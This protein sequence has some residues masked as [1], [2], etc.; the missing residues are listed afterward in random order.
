RRLPFIAESR[1]LGTS[2]RA[3]LQRVPDGEELRLGLID[4]AVRV[5]AGDDAAAGEQAYPRAVDLRAAQC[6]APF[7][8]TVG[9]QPADQTGV[10]PTVHPLEL[11]DYIEGSVG[12]R[13]SYRGGWV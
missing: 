7:P 1:R 9:V 13:A 2:E 5:R 6:D 3:G 11:A 8:V 10:P 12:R 4:L